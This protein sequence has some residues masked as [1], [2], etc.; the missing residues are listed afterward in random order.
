MDRFIT[1]LREDKLSTFSDFDKFK[2]DYKLS[3]ILDVLR[4][5]SRSE[6]SSPFKRPRRDSASKEQ[7]SKKIFEKLLEWEDGESIPVI[8]KP[9]ILLN[10]G[11]ILKFLTHFP[12]S[13]NVLLDRVIELESQQTTKT[14]PAQMNIKSI[15]SHFFDEL[16]LELNPNFATA[17]AVKIFSLIEDKPLPCIMLFLGWLKSENWVHIQLIPTIIY[18]T[19]AESLNDNT[20]LLICLYN[21]LWEA[22]G[23]FLIAGQ[24]GAKQYITDQIGSSLKSTQRLEWEKLE[25]KHKEAHACL[26]H[27]R[28]MTTEVVTAIWAITCQE[29]QNQRIKKARAPRYNSPG[30]PRKTEPVE[31][32]ISPAAHTGIT[33]ALARV[34]SVRNEGLGVTPQG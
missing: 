9:E 19:I 14:R 22:E 31:A 23:G 27:D 24:K 20:A 4:H 15:V 6:S 28:N 13:Y 30:R 32:R 16:E 34:L 3:C 10:P 2:G 26:E 18:A 12:E 7:E 1:A 17:T 11:F 25:A 21:T 5:L 29:D 33:P 8:N